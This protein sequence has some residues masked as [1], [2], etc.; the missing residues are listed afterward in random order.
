MGQQSLPVESD[1]VTYV[2]SCLPQ[3]DSG[4]PK[5]PSEIQHLI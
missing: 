2:P 4:E 5:S 3:K 1:S